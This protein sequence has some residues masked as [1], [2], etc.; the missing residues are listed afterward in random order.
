MSLSL[1]R[2]QKK[3]EENAKEMAL[4]SGW[5]SVVVYTGASNY[6]SNRVLP[7]VKVLPESHPSCRHGLPGIQDASGGHPCEARFR[8]SIW[9]DGTEEHAPKLTQLE[10]RA[11]T[12]TA[13]NR[14]VTLPV[15]TNMLVFVL[16][17]PSQS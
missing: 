1:P 8:H 4:A 13:K 7:V 17:Q 16:M 6:E 10:Q 3:A 12:L 5:S 2:L 9:N 15:A 11:N 14:R